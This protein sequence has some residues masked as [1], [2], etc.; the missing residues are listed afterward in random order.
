VAIQGRGKGKQRI[1]CTHTLSD[2]FF[3]W[4]EEQA[5][6]FEGVVATAVDGRIRRGAG[7]RKSGR[8]A[9]LLFL[10]LL[11][12]F[13]L[14]LL[15]LLLDLEFFLSDT[16]VEFL[17]SP[18]DLV[19]GQVLCVRMVVVEGEFVAGDRGGMV[20]EGRGSGMVGAAEGADGRGPSSWTFP[21]L[22]RSALA[23][24]AASNRLVQ[25][26]QSRPPAARPLPRKRAQPS[27]PIP[28]QLRKTRHHTYRLHYQPHY[29]QKEPHPR[30]RARPLVHPY[31]I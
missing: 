17:L 8:Q 25:P 29:D 11:F 20:G 3:F 5:K 30:R 27:L 22:S 23:P 6:S 2:V 10:L 12:L 9:L 4:G 19:V 21:W 24:S 1:D 15:L 18:T 16:K 26:R 31:H 7:G 13:L 14:L 28:P